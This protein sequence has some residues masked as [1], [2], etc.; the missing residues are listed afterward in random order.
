MPGHH[1]WKNIK[2]SEEFVVNIIGKDFGPLMHI[3]ERKFPYEVSEIEKASLT[4]MPSKI[5]RPPRIKEAIAWIECKLEKAVDLGDHVWIV[6]RVLKVEVKEEFWKEVIN[7]DKVNPLFHIS[8][9]FFAADAKAKK[10]ER[11]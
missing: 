9:E 6:G 7:V 10:Y 1:T 4:E 5:V 2:E 8:G 11:D 3:L